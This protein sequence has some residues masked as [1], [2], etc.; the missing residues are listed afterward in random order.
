M[1]ETDFVPIYGQSDPSLR[2]AYVARQSGA[3]YRA[4]GFI[5]RGLVGAQPQSAPQQGATSS[6]DAMAAMRGL[7]A[8]RAEDGGPGGYGE[9][10]GAL[11]GG[12]QGTRQAQSFN[13][14]LASAAL[15]A[16]GLS[17]PGGFGAVMNT[18]DRMGRD[19]NINGPVEWG[20]V[21]NA[22]NPLSAG[23]SAIGRPLSAAYR[24]VVGAGPEIS[25]DGGFD[26]VT[27]MAHGERA[28]GINRSVTSE[29]LAPPS[30][31]GSGAVPGFDPVTGMAPGERD[32]GIDRSVQSSEIGAVGG[33][34]G[35]PGPSSQGDPT[36]GQGPEHLRMGGP[37]GKPGSKPVPR[38]IVAHT[39]E[40]VQRPEAVNKY[41]PSAM[42]ALNSLRAPA[43]AVKKVTVTKA[44]P[45]RGK[46]N[47]KKGG[48]SDALARMKARR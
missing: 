47:E 10:Q 32:L 46:G 16:L 3:G 17:G 36:G 14:L 25:L 21:L 23:N 48:A 34:A 31:E 11:S 35:D 22:L 7:Y 15:G 13:D 27:G 24:S 9:G 45:S 44:P 18:A 33:G 1:A 4:P 6:G 41:G 30:G 26:P 20:D 40:F 42:A 8:A 39:G 12:Q 38:P 19:R 43:A 5:G 28:M 29:P 2:P 37:V